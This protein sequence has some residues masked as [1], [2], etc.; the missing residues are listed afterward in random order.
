MRLQQK[1][2]IPPILLVAVS[3]GA[4]SLSWVSNHRGMQEILQTSDTTLHVVED[5]YRNEIFSFSE[6]VSEMA[7]DPL[8]RQEP[9]RLGVISI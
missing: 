3:V 7:L 8:L 9:D 1:Q 5:V 6:V 4:Y 2:L